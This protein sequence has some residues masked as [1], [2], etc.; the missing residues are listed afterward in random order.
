[1]KK[2]VKITFIVLAFLA[3]F[4]IG[5]FALNVL[6][7]KP[8]SREMLAYMEKKYGREFQIIDEY[9]YISYTDGEPEVQ[10]EVKCPAIEL[11]DKENRDI[12]CFVY[13]Y[14]YGGSDSWVFG[15]W[16]YRDNYANKVLLYCIQQE[17][18]VINNEEE[19]APITS[20]PAPCLVLENTEE[21]AKKLQNLVMRF[22]EIYRDNSIVKGG[23]VDFRV[24]GSLF[25]YAIRANNARYEEVG[26]FCY[27]MP[28]E[29]Y[30]AFLEELEAENPAAG[31]EE[32]TERIYYVRD[33]KTDGM[34][35]FS[36]FLNGKT[37]AYDEEQQEERY[38]RDYYEE[39]I[40]EYHD[41]S[42]IEIM[43][44][45]V[46]GDSEDE[47]LMIIMYTPD[48]GDLY[49]FH[50]QDGKLYTWEVL[51]S[52]FTMRIGSAYLLKNGTFEF[53]G[54][55]GQGH[56]FK[57][58][59]EKGKVEDV[60]NYYY[61]CYPWE[62]ALRYDY[63]LTTYEQGV[64]ARELQYSII[65]PADKSPDEGELLLGT[66]ETQEECERILDE[67]YE[68]SERLREIQFPQYEERVEEIALDDVLERCGE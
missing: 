14:P 44:E 3:V 10:Q 47:L 23:M 17:E 4:A 5:G 62:D 63:V 51:K 1:M 32:Q 29:E 40:K 15:D 13:A 48:Q 38:C 55:Y 21:T 43:A 30:K 67:F 41:I 34:D 46:N 22:N 25:L 52:F 12:K 33:E 7:G 53:F 37:A 65:A 9:T 19:C 36:D 20:S 8:G 2:W 16:T 61:D 6:I 42:A 66:K 59:N 57:R 35:E 68:E 60:L 18:L 39:Y 64:S 50:E 24:E 26:R 11:Q 56:F 58:Y 49:V 31:G 28:I 54:G 27:D 45:D